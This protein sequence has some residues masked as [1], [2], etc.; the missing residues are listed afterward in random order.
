MMPPQGETGPTAGRSTLTDPARGGRVCG[1]APVSWAATT[2]GR[3]RK[4]S[5]R[6]L[7]APPP[8]ARIRSEPGLARDAAHDRAVRLGDQPIDG[9]PALPGREP[10]LHVVALHEPH[11]D[12]QGVVVGHVAIAPRVPDRADDVAESGELVDLRLVAPAALD[13]AVDERGR[14]ALVR[15]PID[16]SA[17]AELADDQR[18]A[19][20]ALDLVQAI[21]EPRLWEA[22]VARVRVDGDEVEP[23]VAI[24]RQHVERAAADAV[25]VVTDHGLRRFDPVV[26]TAGPE[27]VALGPVDGQ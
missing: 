6:R 24:P 25:G 11:V 16:P 27:P 9:R 5:A 23:G 7:A 8:A 19:G 21:G 18:Q 3:R 15:P 20:F 12:L 14:A 22:R 4:G 26:G 13:L 2:I 10:A 1:A 17:D